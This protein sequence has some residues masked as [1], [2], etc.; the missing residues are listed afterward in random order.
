MGTIRIAAR[1]ENYYLETGDTI[2]TKP[3]AELP[4]PPYPV[5]QDMTLTDAM[6]AWL[7]DELFSMTGTGRT[8]GDATY[9]LVVTASSRP[10]LVP[11]GFTWQ[12]GY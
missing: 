12:W 11:V 7:Q 2:P 3:V 9:D 4:A 5:R 6:D 8:K 1:V 10:D